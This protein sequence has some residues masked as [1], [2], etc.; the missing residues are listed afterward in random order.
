MTAPDPF[1][2]ER[3]VATTAGISECG[4]YRYWLCREW[5][6]GL[7]SLVWLMLNPSTADATQDDPTIRRCMGFA[8]RWGYGGI[9]VVNLYAYRATNPRDL[10]T[11]ADPVGPENDRYC[12][13]PEGKWHLGLDGLE[14][15]S[16][17]YAQPNNSSGASQREKKCATKLPFGATRDDLVALTSA[18]WPIALTST[19]GPLVIPSTK[20]RAALRTPFGATS[21]RSF[22]PTMWHRFRTCSLVVHRS[23]TWS[24]GIWPG[25]SS[26]S[27]GSSGR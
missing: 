14:N 9:T 8:R 19:C 27:T 26:D 16:F 23:D 12:P 11:A 21:G 22:A 20:Q 18:G 24:S 25:C 7:D 3:E 15:I 4:T 1:A 10:L 13:T 2:L 17:G 5:S 6:P